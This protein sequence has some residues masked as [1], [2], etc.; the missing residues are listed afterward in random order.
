[1]RPQRLDVGNLEPRALHAALDIADGVELAIRK[2]ITID[3][4]GGTRFLPAFNVMGDAMVEEQAEGFEQAVN[5]GKVDRQ[6]LQS[7]VLKHADTGHLVV[8]RFT[9]KVA[10]VPQLKR[11]PICQTGL[12]D[13]LTRQLQLSLA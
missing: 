3:E 6:I 11:Y 1:M 13:A 10:V 4:L 7:D 5:G 12:R 9:R 2:D 8:N